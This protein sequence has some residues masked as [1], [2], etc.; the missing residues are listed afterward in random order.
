VFEMRAD[1]G[2]ALWILGVSL[3]LGGVRG[4]SKRSKCLFMDAV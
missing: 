1:V 4:F 3:A 2:L